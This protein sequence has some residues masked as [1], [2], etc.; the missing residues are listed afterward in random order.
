MA[1]G[2]SG[3]VIRRYCGTSTATTHWSK[4]RRGVP[5]HYTQRLSSIDQSKC[6]YQ[7]LGKLRRETFN[8]LTELVGVATRMEGVRGA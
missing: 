5:T 3:N 8:P 6:L 7:N 1:C 2:C 4:R